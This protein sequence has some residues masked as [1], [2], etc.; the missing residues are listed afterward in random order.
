MKMELEGTRDWIRKLWFGAVMA[1]PLI[2]HSGKSANRVLIRGI[3]GS[4][5]PF[6]LLASRA[7]H[8]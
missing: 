5:A 4:R 2:P 6:T 1:L 3:K 8:E 7:M